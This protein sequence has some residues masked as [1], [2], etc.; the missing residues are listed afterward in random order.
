MFATDRKG[1]TAPVA[2]VAA[3]LMVCVAC[4]GFAGLSDAQG[5]DL[6]DTH[7]EYGDANPIDIAPGFSWSYTASFNLEG[8]VLSAAVNDFETAG[9]EDAVSI[10]GM[11][12]V[13][14]IP[15]G[16][17]GYYNLVLQGYHADSEQYAYQWIQFNVKDGIAITPSG[18]I[19]DSAVVGIPVEF[20]ITA[21]A[22]YGTVTSI[23][24]TVSDNDAGSF[25]VTPSGSTVTISG[26]PAVDD[27]GAHSVKVDVET[28]NGE[29]ATKTYTFTVYNDF[30]I[31]ADHTTIGNYEDS[32]VATLS[33]PSDITVSSWT[34][35]DD[36]TEGAI[37]WNS[38]A[39]TITVSSDAYINQAIEIGAMSADGQSASITVTVQNENDTMT[40]SPD[41]SSVLTYFGNEEAKT[42]NMTLSADTGQFSGIQADSYTLASPVTGV[43]IDEGT[44]VVTITGEAVAQQDTT[45]T[46]NATTV[47]GKTLSTTF[48]LNVEGAMT[49]SVADD[50]L[51][52]VCDDEHTVDSELLNGSAEYATVSYTAQATGENASGIQTS[53]VEGKLHI[54]GSTPGQT[55][56]VN[57][58]ASTP[59]G[60]SIT[61]TFTV[62]SY[63]DLAFDSEV[64]AGAI[65]YEK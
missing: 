18:E 10:E 19:L 4:I 63:L 1:L 22:G 25:T 36:Y 65:A 59:A 47:Y 58:T 38:D 40:M 55:Y 27:L 5:E 15:E 31:T 56:T 21:T 20:E 42:V 32:E 43:G 11:T 64:S 28:S 62:T 52:L 17:Q 34:G 7:P 9:F 33:V 57:V 61:E 35:L 39:M 8:T 49:F 14:E 3:F 26:T 51:V 37:V 48:T 23:T 44:G 45:V 50:T 41:S 13:V 24:A 30:V 54:D 6:S 2:V 12:V 29:T 46:V 53:I 60:Q 16:A